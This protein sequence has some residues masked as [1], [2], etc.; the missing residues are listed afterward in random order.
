MSNLRD[1]GAKGDGQTDDTEALQHAI[2]RGDGSL[3]F[4]RGQ[5]LITR[6]LVVPLD[7]VGPVSITG[8]GGLAKLIMAGAGPAIHLVGTHQKTAQPSDLAEGVWRKER[9]PTLDGLEIEGRHPEADGVRAEGVMQ[10]T[11][12]G[13]LVRRCRHGVHLTRRDRNVVISHCHVYDNHGVGIFLDRVNLHQTNILGSHVSYCRQG[14]IRIVGS[15]VRN[16]QICGND[17]EYNFDRN[18]ATSADVLF[19]CREGTAREGTIVGNT[20]Q[21]QKSPG[22]AN[23]RLVGV[24]RD[25][26]N[27]VG[28]L[29]IT[30]NL[31]GSQETLLHLVASRGVVVSGNS[32]YSGFRHAVLA[33]GAEHLVFS[34]NSIDHNPEYKGNSTDRLV[35]RGCRNVTISGVTHQHTRPADG[36]DPSSWEIRDCEN[37]SATGCQIVNARVRGVVV[38]GS[39]VVRIADCTIRGHGGDKEY[40]AAVSVDATSRQVMVVNNFLGKGT[41]GELIIPKDGAVVQGNVML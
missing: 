22:G 7:R 27:A 5:Y 20:I 35:L 21:A 31:I 9:M 10:L 37:V 18:A 1:F 41:D 24:G 6:P 40:R 14:G 19:D 8:S 4:L 17:I 3:V 13:L 30:G 25:N 16:I 11:L 2:D 32:L 33:E 12:H 38:H 23:V 34:G 15:E 26:P 36:D 39:S 28:L 29:A